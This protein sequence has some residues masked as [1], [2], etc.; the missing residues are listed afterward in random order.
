[1]QTT[2]DL[3]YHVHSIMPR[4]AMTGLRSVDSMMNDD[5]PDLAA[6]VQQ[7]TGAIDILDLLRGEMEQWLE[8]AQ[9]ESK[10]ECL[11]N[12]LGHISAVET[13]YRQRLAAAQDEAAG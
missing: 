1:M 2:T 5:Q 8:E 13:E 7:L 4:A 6:Q 9:D 11:E 12:V 3:I 10:R